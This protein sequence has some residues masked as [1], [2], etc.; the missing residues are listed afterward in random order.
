MSK[1]I[2]EILSPKPQVLP[3]IYAYSIDDKAHLGLL[4]VGQTTR[5][6]YRLRIFAKNIESNNIAEA[7][8]KSDTHRTIEIYVK[9]K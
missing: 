3:S 2:D 1:T 8:I 5:N 4:K 6:V 7:D 9:V